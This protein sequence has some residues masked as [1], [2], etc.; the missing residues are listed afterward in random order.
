MRVRSLL[1]DDGFAA[2]IAVLLREE[3][4]EKH[5]EAGEVPQRNG[6]NDQTTITQRRD[7]HGAVPSI[8]TSVDRDGLG[9]NREPEGHSDASALAFQARRC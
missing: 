7:R 2:T 8:R 6:S 9:R 1:P 4:A 3:S 5:E